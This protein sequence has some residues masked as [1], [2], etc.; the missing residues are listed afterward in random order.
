[1][2]KKIL[3]LFAM[4]FVLVVVSVVSTSAIEI[5]TDHTPI[6]GYPSVAEHDLMFSTAYIQSQLGELIDPVFNY[7]VML[8]D[9]T[10]KITLYVFDTLPKPNYNSNNLIVLSMITGRWAYY[11]WSSSGWV[12]YH[13]YYMGTINLSPSLILSTNMNLPLADG[14]ILTGNNSLYSWGTS[15]MQ[16][17]SI[18]TYKSNVKSILTGTNVGSYDDGYS[19]G[20]DVGYDYGYAMGVTNA[21]MGMQQTIQTEKE[22]S[23]SEG[24]NNGLSYGYSNGYDE[25]L[26]TG[27]GDALDYCENNNHEQIRD[28]A[29]N[30]G[31]LTGVIVGGNTSETILNETYVRGYN[32]GLTVGYNGG[33]TEG[34]EL[35]IEMG[36]EICEDENHE[37]IFLQGSLK[38]ADTERA[39]WLIEEAKWKDNSDLAYSRGYTDAL[40]T[41]DSVLDYVDAIFSAPVHF[42][43]D[44]FNI[45]LFGINLFNVIM[46]VLSIIIVGVVVYFIMK[47]R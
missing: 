20:Y 22:K 28:T 18:K 37:E 34:K 15:D 42:L 31:Y 47:F 25:G 6:L 19:A 5:K 30:E 23:Y 1:M 24:Y 41:N 3:F 45:E 13:I 21:Q 11:C 26:L 14:A 29:Y 38:G 43:Y 32:E 35:G 7:Y 44:A 16:A 40:N 8:S 9:T 17:S 39:K 10:G 33:L 2:K 4:L 36:K 12:S 27:Y 46:L